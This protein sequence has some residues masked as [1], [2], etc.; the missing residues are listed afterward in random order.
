MY[1]I[2]KVR[3]YNMKYLDKLL[4]VIMQATLNHKNLPNISWEIEYK[5]TE[6]LLSA[7]QRFGYLTSAVGLWVRITGLGEVGSRVNVDNYNHFTDKTA[8]RS[9]SETSE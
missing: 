2:L 4:T 3:V 7:L 5:E 6:G 9:H 8:D 1:T